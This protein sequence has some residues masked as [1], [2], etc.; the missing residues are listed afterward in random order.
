MAEQITEVDIVKLQLDLQNPRLPTTIE[1]TDRS[2][3]TW[4]AKTTAIEGLM[5][6]IGQNGYFPGEPVIVY[7]AT[8]QGYYIVVEGNR[9]LVAVR[10]LANPDECEKPSSAILQAAEQAKFRPT[11]LPVVVRESRKEILPYLGYRHITGIK[12]WDPIAKARYLAQLFDATN[13]QMATEKRYR[14]VARTIGG[15]K[16]TV[17]RNLDALAVYRVMEKEDFFDIEGLDEE[18]I[19]FAVLSTAVSDDR[20]GAFVGTAKQTSNEGTRPTYERTFPI[21]N[22]RALKKESIEELSRW[23]FERKDDRTVVGESRNLRQLGAVVATPKALSALRKGS[24][25]AYA[26]RLTSGVEEDFSGH[27]YEAQSSLERAA[28]IVANVKY[29]DATHDITRQVY[30]QAQQ[31]HRAIADKKTEDDE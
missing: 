4:I 25:L 29:S 11:K 30:K 20:I 9:R 12:E 16:T 8:K 21:V 7:P 31:V 14:Q 13:S 15:K 10:L 18:S 28:G 27:M 23:L 17:E 26:F 6:A 24:S 22:H 5:T 3:L 19:K 1:K 2:I